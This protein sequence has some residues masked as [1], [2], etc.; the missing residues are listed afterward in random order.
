MYD[1]LVRF[2]PVSG[3]VKSENDKQAEDKPNNNLAD[4]LKKVGKEKPIIENTQKSKDEL[5]E[6]LQQSK[7]ASQ[8]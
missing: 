8:G 5:E 7:Q 2:F 4:L 6:E 1:I 3:V